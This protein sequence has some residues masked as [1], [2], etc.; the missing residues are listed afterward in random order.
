[1]KTRFKLNGVYIQPP[2]NA[3]ELSIQLNFDKDSPTAQVS[4]NKWRFVRDNAGTIQDYIDGG[5]QIAPTLYGG[6][7]G[8][9][10]GIFEGLPFQI[11]VEDEGI[12]ELVFNGF[13]DLTDDVEVSCNDITATAKEVHKIDWLNETADSVDYQFLF[14]TFPSY[15]TNKFVSVPYVINTIPKGLETIMA[16]VSTFVIIMELRRAVKDLLAFVAEVGNPFAAISSIIKLV[17]YIIYLIA[18]IVSLIDLVLQIVNY[19]IQPVKYHAAMYVR[20]LLQIGATHFGFT[21]QSSIFLDKESALYNLVILPEKYQNPEFEGIFGFLSPNLPDAKGF[22]KGT[23]GQLLREVKNMCNAKIVIDHLSNP[24]APKLIIERWD[25]D[26]FPQTNWTLPDLRNDWNGFNANEFKSG[27]YIKFVTDINDKN[28]IDKY[29]GTAYQITFQP[30]VKAAVGMSLFKG[31][32]TISIPFA[33]GK[34]KA[35][36]TWV[37]EVIKVFLDVFNVVANVVVSAANLAILGINAILGAINQLVKFLRTFGINIPFHAESITP[38]PP[39]SAGD[40]MSDRIGMLMLENDF[41]DVPKM[42]IINE[43]STPVKTDIIETLTAKY[44]WDNFKF[45]N[46]FQPINGKHNQMLKYSHDKVPFCFDDFEK[47]KMDN[48]FTTN[49]GEV[50][51]IDSLEWNVYRQDAKIKYRVNKLYYDAF[52]EAKINEATGN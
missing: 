51:Y 48:R 27:Y 30:K 20:D 3:K 12:T 35:S 37:E 34:R 47:I 44:L 11:E 24:A 15:F 23:F 22:Y 41:V 46:S 52:G 32:E 28:T 4:I 50:G 36:L 31:Y 2:A 6:N 39:F 42:F 10:N 25:Y 9:S 40:L 33:L 1:M 18:L 8:G 13:L 26:L 29:E 38:I 16:L 21:L 5:L 49:F 7:A 14:D 19:L 43:G 45:I 17:G